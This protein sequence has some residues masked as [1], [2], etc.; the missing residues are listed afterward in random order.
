MHLGLLN[1]VDFWIGEGKNGFDRDDYKYR[2]YVNSEISEYPGTSDYNACEDSALRLSFS[3]RP[4]K[5]HGEQEV[6][7]N[8]RK[9]VGRRIQPTLHVPN[10]V[11]TI[12]QYLN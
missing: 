12:S 5:F 3:A 11:K 10:A 4:I 7:T 6:P 8:A 2:V 1:R 9:R